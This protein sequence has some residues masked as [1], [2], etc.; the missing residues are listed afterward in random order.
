[1]LFEKK[2]FFFADCVN[3]VVVVSHNEHHVFS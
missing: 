1:V 3:N 2:L